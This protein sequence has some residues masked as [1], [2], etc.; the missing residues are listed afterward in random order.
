M[1]YVEEFNKYVDHQDN[2][3]SEK[4]EN[5]ENNQENTS[6]EAEFPGKTDEKAEI[7]KEEID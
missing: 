4:G 6:I 1:S 5:D 3:A 7:E 2:D